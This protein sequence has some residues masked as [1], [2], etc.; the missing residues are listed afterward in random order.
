MFTM[1]IASTN[2]PERNRASR[3]PGF[4]RNFLTNSHTFNPYLPSF[5]VLFQGNEDMGSVNIS[6]YCFILCVNQENWEA[7]GSSGFFCATPVVGI[8]CLWLKYWSLRGAFHHPAFI[9]NS[10]TVS[11]TFLALSTQWMNSPSRE[12]RREFSPRFHLI[13]LCLVWIKRTRR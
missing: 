8:L 5:W 1:F 6:S 10:P 2:I 3:L 13:V 11:H 9:C 12:W 4:K 7:G